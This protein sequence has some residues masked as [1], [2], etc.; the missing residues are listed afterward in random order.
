M[1]AALTSLTAWTLKQV[2]EMVDRITSVS[3]PRV[4][5]IGIDY[6]MLI[7]QL[8]ATLNAE[9]TM[10]FENGVRYRYRSSLAALW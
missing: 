3:K 7:D 5:I 2:I 9:R 8:A 10:Q 6:S 4:I 1:G